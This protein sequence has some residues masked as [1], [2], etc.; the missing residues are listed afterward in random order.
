[1][2]LSDF[3]TD[4]KMNLRDKEEVWVLLSGEDLVWVVGER[5]DN[6]FRVTE[7]TKRGLQIKLCPEN[8]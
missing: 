2:K 1:K 6:R 4:R 5:P 3:F 8:V 7:K